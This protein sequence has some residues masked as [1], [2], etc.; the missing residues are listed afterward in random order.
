MGS[1]Q[2]RPNR[3]HDPEATRGI[4]LSDPPLPIHQAPNHA[5]STLPHQKQTLNCP[6]PTPPIGRSPS[7]RTASPWPW[8]TTASTPSRKGLSASRRCPLMREG[9][10]RHR[11]APDPWHPVGKHARSRQERPGAVLNG[12][13]VTPASSGR[14]GVLARPRYN[15]DRPPTY[16]SRRSRSLCESVKSPEGPAATSYIRFKT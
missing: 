10:P 7:V 1:R 4:P 3:A 16:R 5:G 9:N 6:R 8:S 15:D 14:A 13:A 11:L 12:D 2:T